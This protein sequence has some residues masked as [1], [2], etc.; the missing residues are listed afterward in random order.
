MAETRNNPYLHSQ[1][2]VAEAM[3]LSKESVRR[4][5]K[6]ALEKA[7]AYCDAHGITLDRLADGEPVGMAEQVRRQ[8][9]E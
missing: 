1:S 5:E 7:R 9:S 8:A 2:E 3:G 6:R 4:I